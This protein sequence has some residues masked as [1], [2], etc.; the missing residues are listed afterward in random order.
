VLAISKGNYEELENMEKTYA[1][2]KVRLEGAKSVISKIKGEIDSSTVN[3]ERYIKKTTRGSS[4]AKK[5]LL[6]ANR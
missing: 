4:F 5:P 2:K 1:G 3:H 6:T